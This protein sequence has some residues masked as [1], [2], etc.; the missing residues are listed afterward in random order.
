MS[1]PKN[2]SQMPYPKL[3][4]YVIQTEMTLRASSH[5][6]PLWERTR[7]QLEYA[8]SATPNENRSV[9][10]L[11]PCLGPL[12]SGSKTWSGVNKSSVTSYHRSKNVSFTNW[13]DLS[14]LVAWSQHWPTLTSQTNTSQLATIRQEDGSR[15]KNSW[16][17]CLQVLATADAGTC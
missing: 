5:Y 10:R 14:Q 9:S 3:N 16:Q 2:K 1:I 17:P 13:I 12:H 11:S 15:R 4:H 7:M 8:T 6:I